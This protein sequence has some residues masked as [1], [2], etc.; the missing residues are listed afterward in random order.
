MEKRI[1]KKIELYVTLFKDKIRDKITE[2]NM[3]D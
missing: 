3:N 1:N 2:L